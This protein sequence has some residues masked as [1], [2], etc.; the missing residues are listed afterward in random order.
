MRQLLLILILTASPTFAAYCDKLPLLTKKLE[1]AQTP[2]EVLAR[3]G[4]ARRDVVGA[5]DEVSQALDE[6]YSKYQD[7]LAK[8]DAHQK[9]TKNPRPAEIQQEVESLRKELA[10][11][12]G[13]SMGKLFGK[14]PD[15]E[16]TRKMKDRLTALGTELAGLE[17]NLAELKEK[18]DEASKKHLEIST[19]SSRLSHALDQYEAT[20]GWRYIDTALKAEILGHAVSLKELPDFVV[21]QTMARN[22]WEVFTG[23]ER[24]YIFSFTL[25][26]ATG[27]K[28]VLLVPDP[29]SS[30][31]ST[32]SFKVESNDPADTRAFQQYM[33]KVIESEDGITASGKS[34]LQ[35]MVK[36]EG[37][38]YIPFGLPTR[39][40]YLRSYDSL[41]VFRT[42]AAEHPFSVR[43]LS[44]Q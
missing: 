4:D 21:V 7:Y 41:P 30:P 23:D 27:T 24:P 29:V 34:E 2:A 10:K 31:G 14:K 3:F 40:S 37:N 20:L 26:L 39:S 1:E 43:R 18:S 22:D 11:L 15:P 28:N 44:P 5:R 25:P 38:G 17:K 19:A 13:F 35:A 12:E 9:E 42:L 36:N 6:R 32:F 16:Q 8:R 33:A